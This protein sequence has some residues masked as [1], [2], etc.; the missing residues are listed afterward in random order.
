[1]Y[2]YTFNIY[3]CICNIWDNFDRGLDNLDT[4][5]KPKSITVLLYNSEIVANLGED[6]ITVHAEYRQF[7]MSLQVA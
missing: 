7:S 5:R 3:T 1:M 6:A 4:M 2:I